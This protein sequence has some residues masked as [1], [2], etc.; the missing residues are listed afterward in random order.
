MKFKKQRLYGESYSYQCYIN[1]NGKD[2]R[3][4]RIDEPHDRECKRYANNWSVVFVGKFANGNVHNLL[5]ITNKIK[6]LAKG[7]YDA[8][9]T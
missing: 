8:Q 2:V 4:A 7:Y 1:K 3:V 5:K 9:T 6:K